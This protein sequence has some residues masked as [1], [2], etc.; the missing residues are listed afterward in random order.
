MEGR[1]G[2]GVEGLRDGDPEA[3][4]RVVRLV[5]LVIRD[6]AYAVPPR[7]R[8]DVVQQVLVDVWRSLS[9]PDFK[10]EG[11]LDTFV[12]TVAYRRCVDWIRR[13]RPEDPIDELVPG[14]S[15]EG[16]E[17]KLEIAERRRL[18]RQ[19]LSKLSDS[20]RELMHLRVVEGLR[21]VEIA[22][23]QDRSDDAVRSQFYKCLKAARAIA[24]KL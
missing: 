4:A 9:R 13:Q 20:C 8:P 16:P 5:S 21:L 15:S 7:D 23:R 19:I 12:R 24:E 6:R 1:A 11:N 18:G 17:R 3:A 2:S 14:E 22:R 10:F